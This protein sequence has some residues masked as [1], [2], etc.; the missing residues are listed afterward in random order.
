MSTTVSEKKRMNTPS[1]I[2]K[3]PTKT[4]RLKLPTSKKNLQELFDWIDEKLARADCDC[5]LRHT[6]EFIRKRGLDEAVVVDWLE[7][8]GGYCNCE[9][10]L[11]VDYL[12]EVLH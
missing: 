2:V 6:R 8:H 5:T 11:S 9:V 3:A 4:A 12:G 1:M 7:D 10:L